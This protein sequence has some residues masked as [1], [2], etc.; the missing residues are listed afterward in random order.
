MMATNARIG[1]IIPGSFSGKPP[2]LSEFTEFFRRVDDLGFHALWVID[3]LFH[4]IN[5]LEPLTL[6][7]C[8]AA[9]T[10]RI[11]LGTSVILFVLRNP[12]LMAKTTATLDYL[13]G[14]RL[15]LGVSLGGR[16]QEF[17]ALDVPIKQR[18]SRL[19]EQLT[20]MRHLWAEQQVTFHGRYYHLDNV[21]MGPKPLQKPGIPILMGGRAD[22]VLK[23]SAEQA[24][25]WIA[26]GQGSPE[27]FHEAWQKVRGYAKAAGKDPDALDSGKLLYITVGEDRRLCQEQLTA[28]THA[29]YGPQYDVANNCV[30]G[31]PTECAAKIQGF[32]DAGAKTI[33]LGPTW[34]DVE[35]VTRIAKEVVP[36]LQ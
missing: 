22:A 14:G 29:Y 19:Q 9:V 10:S 6:L 35:Q 36:E 7:T 33:I 27:V 16:D 12:V 28:F 3:R 24:D 26:G 4:H 13:S 25:G 11:R 23:R 17:E 32:I 20:V 34:P 8:A 2:A 21:N 30:F 5:I 18:V 1:F 31:S 15:I